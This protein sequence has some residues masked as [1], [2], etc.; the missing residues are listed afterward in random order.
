MGEES[1]LTLGIVFAAKRKICTKG[2]RV[3]SWIDIS[4]FPAF[5]G[6]LFFVILLFFVV[7][8]VFASDTLDVTVWTRRL[9]RTVRKRS[10]SSWQIL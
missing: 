10:A 1:V 8:S 7:Q 3:A 2:I 4:A 5:L 9:E 6:V